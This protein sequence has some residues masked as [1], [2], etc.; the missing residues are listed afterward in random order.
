MQMLPLQ[1]SRVL[2]VYFAKEPTLKTLFEGYN[3]SFN[4]RKEDINEIHENNN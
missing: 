4:I 3:I 2:Y 1:L